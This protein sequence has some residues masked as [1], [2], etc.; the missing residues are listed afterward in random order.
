[1]MAE[2]VCTSKHLKVFAE[3]L[4]RVMPRNTETIM[5]TEHEN[6]NNEQTYCVLACWRLSAPV[7]PTQ[8]YLY[9]HALL[10]PQETFNTIC[11]GT[12]QGRCAAA[13]ANII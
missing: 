6:A 10:W 9:M 5:V 11:Y 8:S 2:A 12:M 13:N 1:M 4:E 3:C 7:S